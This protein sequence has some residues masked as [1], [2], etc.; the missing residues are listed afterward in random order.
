MP[1]LPDLQNLGSRRLA[2]TPV[3]GDQMLSSGLHMYT[4][5]AVIHIKV[6][7]SFK[8]LYIGAVDLAKDLGLVPRTHMGAHGH[9]QL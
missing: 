4:M 2:V 6:N 3:P 1:Q 9:P 5:Q 8:K 7:I